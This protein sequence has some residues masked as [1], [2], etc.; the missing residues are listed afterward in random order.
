[1]GGQVASTGGGTSV[2][3]PGYI[4]PAYI[5]NRLRLRFDAGWE[6]NRPDRAEYFYGKC[7]CFRPNGDPHAPGPRFP[8]TSVNFQEIKAYGEFALQDNFSL[9]VEAPVRFIDPEV[10][11]DTVGFGDLQFGA[12]FGIIQDECTALTFQ[13][14]AYAPTGLAAGGLGTGHWSVEPG[15][16][17]Q[18]Q[19]SDRVAFLGEFLAWI[20]ID[21]TDFAGDILQYG[22]GFK[23][24]AYRSC[25]FQASPIA[26]LVGWTVLNGK[27]SIFPGAVDPTTG[28]PAEATKSAGGDTIVNAKFGIRFN[29]GDAQTLYFGY[30]RALTGAVWYKDFLR[31]EYGLRF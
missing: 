26:E 18:Q 11:Q 1:M 31:A 13:V 5:A 29:L 24:D 27:E 10:N 7:G 21:A 25:Q 19:L 9:F 15:L 20:P 30:G 28:L 6:D 12:R 4:D 3:D 14:R 23:Y 22:V 8:E 16:L 17:V 2:G